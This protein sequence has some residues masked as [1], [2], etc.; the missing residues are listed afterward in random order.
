MG[1]LM[2]AFRDILENEDVGSYLII[3]K[4]IVRFINK[5]H[6]VHKAALGM[7]KRKL[8]RLFKCGNS[9]IISL[10]PAVC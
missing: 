6:K 10:E 2:C 1:R 7:A 3:L 8:K 4:G 5:L 9:H